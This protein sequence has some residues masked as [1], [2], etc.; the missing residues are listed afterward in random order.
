M[1]FDDGKVS[2]SGEEEIRQECMKRC[3]PKK[4]KDECYRNCVQTYDHRK[5]VKYRKDRGYPMISGNMVY[6]V[7][8]L[9]FG[10]TADKYGD[11]PRI[12]SYD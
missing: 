11:E 2:S 4:N 5:C 7:D 12:G 10:N 9:M 6:C 8:Y 1:S 3:A